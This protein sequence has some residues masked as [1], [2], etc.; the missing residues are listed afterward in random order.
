MFTNERFSA[1]GF[2]PFEDVQII[3]P[4]RK[5]ALG[6]LELNKMMQAYFQ[7]L[8]DNFITPEPEGK[9]YKIHEGDKV[10]QTKNDY[11]LDVMNGTLGI[12]KE[13]SYGDP[14][15]FE[16]GSQGRKMEDAN[17]QYYKILFETGKF[18]RIKKGSEKASNIELA[19]ALTIHKVQGSEF[20]CVVVVCHKLHN[21]MHHRG[22]LYT[23][24]TRAKKSVIILGDRWGVTNCAKVIKTD[25]RKTLLPIFN[26]N[27]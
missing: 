16:D 27:L 24:V 22:L 14:G 18:L 15:K 8:R 4:Q 13:I 5:G 19:Y 23:A 1:N 17:G 20:P 12:V 9:K 3:S 10:I 6:T 2:R 26:K 25:A 7:K 21:F 11:K